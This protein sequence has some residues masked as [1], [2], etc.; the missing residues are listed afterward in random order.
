M[1]DFTSKFELKSKLQLH[2]VKRFGSFANPHI[3][4]NKYRIFPHTLEQHVENVETRV[5]AQINFVCKS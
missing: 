2:M 5:T 1:L 3:S 4:D